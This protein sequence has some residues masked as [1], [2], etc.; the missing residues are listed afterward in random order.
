M[1]PCYGVHITVCMALLVCVLC[2]PV[3]SCI[4]PSLHGLDFFLEIFLWR[5]VSVL[6]DTCNNLIFVTH[7]RPRNCGWSA[8]DV[9]WRM[10]STTSTHCPLSLLRKKA[11]AVSPSYAQNKALK[12]IPREFH[13]YWWL[14]EH[15]T[16]RVTALGLAEERKKEQFWLFRPFQVCLFKIVT[17]HC[18]YY[19]KLGQA[20]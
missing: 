20:L 14:L 3:H 15:Y 16:Y 9:H 18:Y 4:E 6:F 17:T 11:Q 13:G 2:Q 10:A 1:L 8:R 7:C 5:L 19:C 12:N